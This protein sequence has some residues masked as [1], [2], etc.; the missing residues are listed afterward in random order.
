MK[1]ASR[2]PSEAKVVVRPQKAQPSGPF[3]AR[4][5]RLAFSL[6]RRAR[7]R[8]VA[9]LRQHSPRFVVSM[10][11]HA[12][13]YFSTLQG[14][15]I[16]FTNGWGFGLCMQLV[17]QNMLWRTNLGGGFQPLNPMSCFTNKRRLQRIL[18][19]EDV[20]LTGRKTC[21]FHRARHRQSA[22]PPLHKETLSD[23][24]TDP[25]KMD[26]SERAGHRLVNFSSKHASLAHVVFY[27]EIRPEFLVPKRV[28]A[29]K[30]RPSLGLRVEVVN[31]HP[32]ILLKLPCLLQSALRLSAWHATH[33]GTLASTQVQQRQ[34]FFFQ[35]SLTHASAFENKE[36]PFLVHHCDMCANLRF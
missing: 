27:G 9:R 36:P 24:H 21:R 10:E 31:L 32:Q 30:I 18:Q 19:N 4:R 16:G 8:L 11:G 6:L 17:G 13:N 7:L 26:A 35:C 28:E 1:M 29:L 3:P 25:A 14:I 12:H 33:S 15:H 22:P 20:Q 5:K 23:P 2:L 34:L